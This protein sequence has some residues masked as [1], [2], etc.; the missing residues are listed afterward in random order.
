MYKNVHLSI[1]FSIE[2]IMCIILKTLSINS[3]RQA[4]FYC[5][6]KRGKK[7]PQNNTSCPMARYV[8]SNRLIFV[9]SLAETVNEI[10]KKYL[11]NY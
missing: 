10:F 1:L 9:S 2:I 8:F 6:F 11:I 3:D 7:N 5:K 4:F